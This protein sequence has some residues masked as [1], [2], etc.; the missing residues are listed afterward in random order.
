MMHTQKAIKMNIHIWKFIQTIKKFIRKEMSETENSHRYVQNTFW[1]TFDRIFYSSPIL[2]I[3]FVVHSSI[4]PSDSYRFD[5]VNV[6]FFYYFTEKQSIR[7]SPDWK[8]VN[9]SF[10]NC[11]FWNQGYVGKKTHPLTTILY[12][13]L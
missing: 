10:C 1:Y 4:H 3:S 12:N 7:W 5:C 2:R 11:T 9:F 13:F 6:F 8:I